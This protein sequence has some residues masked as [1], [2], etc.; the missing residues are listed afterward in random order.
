MHHL[1][2]LLLQPRISQFLKPMSLSRT[3]ESSFDSVIHM[4]ALFFTCLTFLN[5]KKAVDIQINEMESN[6]SKYIQF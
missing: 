6:I 5:L 2:L 4:I 3:A 1:C